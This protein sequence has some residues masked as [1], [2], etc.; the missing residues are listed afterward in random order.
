MCTVLYI[1]TSIVNLRNYYEVCHWYLALLDIY[2]RYCTDPVLSGLVGLVNS[3]PILSGLD[4]SPKATW[5]IH[6]T[7]QRH[8]PVDWYL[9]GQS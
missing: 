5:L 6:V 3:I 2:Q 1:Q 9:P 7:S 8:H 4:G